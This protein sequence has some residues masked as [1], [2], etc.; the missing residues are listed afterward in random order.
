MAV[1][2]RSLT[3]RFN[4]NGILIG[5]S[6]AGIL[7]AVLPIAAAIV[8]GVTGRAGPQT[9]YAS[10]PA[11]QYAVIAQSGI[12]SDTILVTPV[13]D[14]SASMEIASVP[15]LDGF[16]TRGAVA[17]DGRTAALIVVDGG[18]PAEPTA[19]LVI[20]N[21]ESGETAKVAHEIDT[22]QAPLWTPDSGTVIVTRGGDNAPGTITLLAVPADGGPEVAL[23]SMGGVLGVY[24]VGHDSLGRLVTVVIDGEG[25]TAYRDGAEPVHLG[26]SITRDWELNADGS[27]IAYVETNLQQGA[28]YLPRVTSLVGESGGVSAQSLALEANIQALGASW[29]PSSNE[30][31][32][33]SEPGT[34]IESG[35]VLAQSVASDGF[36]VPLGYST[37]GSYL[38]VQHWDGESFSRP[39]DL[40][41][42][43]VSGEGRVR[44]DSA[45][46]FLGWAA[47]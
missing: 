13:H 27:A 1:Q 31:V 16:Y 47:R 28:R 20:V 29:D 14:P 15:H 33:G 17:P 46:E 32:F 6:V 2:A 25:S 41:I 36:D 7:L 18:T 22:L 5:L 43:I 34:G 3:R 24:P 39:G 45:T 11:G 4:F 12:E 26:P 30:P 37:D 19:S 40:S 8:S 9:A 42:E 21:L 23:Q 44:L 10:A 35:S 38:A